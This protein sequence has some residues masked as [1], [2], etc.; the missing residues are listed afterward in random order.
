M[1]GRADGGTIAFARD[2]QPHVLR[3]VTGA[4]TGLKW[5]AGRRDCL[6]IEPGERFCRD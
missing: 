4:E 2:G 5:L 6:M 1:D 3:H